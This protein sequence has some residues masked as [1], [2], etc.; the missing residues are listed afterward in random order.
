MFDQSLVW[1]DILFF[2]SSEVSEEDSS[3]SSN[4]EKPSIFNL[5]YLNLQI[6]S[7]VHHIVLGF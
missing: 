5:T 4:Q 6:N 7:I 1:P 2:L 3:H